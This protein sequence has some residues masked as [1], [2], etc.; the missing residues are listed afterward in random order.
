MI[1]LERKKQPKEANAKAMSSGGSTNQS[2]GNN[3]LS[4]LTQMFSKLTTE[5]ES[6]Y[7]SF[8]ENDEN[9]P[10]EK[11][12]NLMVGKLYKKEAKLEKLLSVITKY[13]R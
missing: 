1:D 13:L 5:T 4:G 12:L 8:T 3:I 10:E 2:K 11:Y 7:L 6:W 9:A